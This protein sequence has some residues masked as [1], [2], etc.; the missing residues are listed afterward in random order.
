MY[1]QKKAKKKMYGRRA[2]DLKFKNDKIQ[3]ALH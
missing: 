3:N 1:T 2:I